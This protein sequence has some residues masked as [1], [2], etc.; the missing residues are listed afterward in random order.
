[1]TSGEDMKKRQKETKGI[2]AFKDKEA[3]QRELGLE[4]ERIRRKKTG[5][6]L[7]EAGKREAKEQA[8]QGN[9]FASKTDL[10]K[11]QRGPSAP[12][13]GKEQGGKKG[14]PGAGSRS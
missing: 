6:A 11:E 9:L 1:M 2:P 13:S 5:D 4:Q 12:Y 10:P 14:N 3:Y 8:G 7:K